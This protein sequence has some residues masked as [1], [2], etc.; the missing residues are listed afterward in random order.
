MRRPR[1]ALTAVALTALVGATACNNDAAPQTDAS[2]P[3]RSAIS[4]ISRTRTQ[5]I[6]P[7]LQAIGFD[8][9]VTARVSAGCIWTVEPAGL[10]HGC[11]DGLRSVGIIALL[12][13]SGRVTPVPDSSS[14]YGWR[15]EAPGAQSGGDLTV[16]L[17]R[18]VVSRRSNRQEWSEG[19]ARYVAE[20][21]TYNVQRSSDIGAEGAQN[22]GP[23][24]FR[25]VLVN[26][27][28]AGAWRVDDSTERPGREDEQIIRQVSDEGVAVSRSLVER[29]E[30][31]QAQGLRQR[32]LDDAARTAAREASRATSAASANTRTSITPT[33][34]E[35][36]ELTSAWS[37][38]IAI[39]PGHHLW[40][41]DIDV[42]PECSVSDFSGA[43]FTFECRDAV[44]GPSYEF[45]S[46]RCRRS[47]ANRF[48][49]KSSESFTLLYRFQP[50]R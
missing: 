33:S 9:P 19:A 18:R 39:P 24:S 34:W 45:S 14:R 40:V 35:R 16:N 44:D 49:S 36:V 27:P 13:R 26:H 2:E 43:R 20:T 25:L 7:F 8:Q 46:G 28:A 3:G 37:A 22:F 4:D 23:F 32:L 47:M 15:M 11:M 10:R 50:S 6:Q 29:I 41:C 48:R 31:A 42:D 5:D 12:T 38:W 17:G 1:G 30:A 21:I